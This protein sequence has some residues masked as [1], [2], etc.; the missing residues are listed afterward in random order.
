[1]LDVQSLCVSYG[2]R[3]VLK[4]L[5]FDLQPGSILAVIGP[6]GA[7]K[8][9]L[10]R[11]L[12]GIVP[13][14]SGDV[15]VKDRS[16]TRLS[17]TDRSRW[18]AVVPQARNLPPAFTAWETVLLGRTPHLNWL[19]QS[20]ARDEAIAREAMARTQTLELAER[21]VGELSGGEQQRVLLA[22]ALTQ[23]APILLL[24]EP[25][26]HLDLQFQLALL[27]QVRS[28]ALNDKLAVLIILHDLNLAARYADRTALLVQGELRALGPTH[29]ILTPDLL[30]PVYHVPLEILHAG[31]QNLPFIFP[32]LQ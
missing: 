25:T 26:S 7:G 23:S 12:T 6:N 30:S 22:R 24:D 5:T 8:T 4:S 10:V 27:D 11:A 18:I 17:V 31:P 3:Q 15:R 28:L 20:S 2:S 13:I 16:L 29:E 1:M 9:T 21:P 32:S 14:Q 19:G